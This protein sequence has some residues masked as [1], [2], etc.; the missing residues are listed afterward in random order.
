MAS[1]RM[2]PRHTMSTLMSSQ[3]NE[4]TQGELA[5]PS[6]LSRWIRGLLL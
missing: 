4:R 2:G 1:L 6:R 3:A 5:R